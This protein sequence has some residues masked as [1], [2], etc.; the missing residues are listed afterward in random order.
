M[1]TQINIISSKE[2]KDLSLKTVISIPFHFQTICSTGNSF[3]LTLLLLGFY[4]YSPIMVFSFFFF[5]RMSLELIL[6][7]Q[8]LFLIDGNSKRESYVFFSSW[9][10]EGDYND[11]S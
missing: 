2:T 11:I 7:L 10:F 4:L 5:N 6:K 3:L 9:L 1:S 8:F